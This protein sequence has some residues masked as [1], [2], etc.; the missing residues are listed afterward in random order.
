MTRSARRPE[1]SRKIATPCSN[2]GGPTCPVS[3]RYYHMDQMIGMALAEAEKLV[4][5]YS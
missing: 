3:Y 1:G 2:N 4:A 5:R